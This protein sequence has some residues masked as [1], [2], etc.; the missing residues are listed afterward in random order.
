MVQEF[1]SGTSDLTNV[2]QVQRQLL[3]Y[4]LKN[5]EAIADYNIMAASIQKLISFKD[6]E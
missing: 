3:D 1:V 6:T 2:I 4:Q 5:V